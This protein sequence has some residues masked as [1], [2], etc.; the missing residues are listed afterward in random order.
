LLRLGLRTGGGAVTL[1]NNNDRLM[2]RVVYGTDGAWPAAP[3]GAGPSLAK[4]NDS[5]PLL[6]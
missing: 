5:G 3:D 6:P 1:R 4:A 2:D